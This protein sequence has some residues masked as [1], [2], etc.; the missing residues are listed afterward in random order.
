[1]KN[2]TDQWIQSLLKSV[3][4]S[5]LPT[6]EQTERIFKNVLHQAPVKHPL[7][8]RMMRFAALYPWRFAFGV[9]AIQAVTCR[10]IFGTDYTRFIM[11]LLGG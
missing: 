8:L 6:H 2:K 1:M 9:S 10:L 3:S 7:A 11:G 5:A 4:R